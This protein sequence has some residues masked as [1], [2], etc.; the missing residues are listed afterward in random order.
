MAFIS[1]LHLYSLGSIVFC[2]FDPSNSIP[3]YPDDSG[4]GIECSRSPLSLPT[5]SLPSGFSPFL[6]DKEDSS[7]SSVYRIAGKKLCAIGQM[8]EE[9]EEEEEE[10]HQLIQHQQQQ[11]PIRLRQQQ[12]QQQQQ[13]PE[14]RLH[15]HRPTQHRPTRHRP[16]QHQQL[17]GRQKTLTTSAKAETIRDTTLLRGRSRESA[18]STATTTQRQISHQQLPRWRPQKMMNA[19]SRPGN[20]NSTSFR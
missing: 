3:G 4:T 17:P 12:Q 13:Q 14:Q 10:E 20:K 15:R 9:E 16:T 8:E 6:D 5:P 7:V 19:K 2:V 11:Q 1:T 18:L